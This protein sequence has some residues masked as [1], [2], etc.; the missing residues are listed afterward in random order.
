MLQSSIEYNRVLQ[1]FAE[2][3]RLLQNIT[4][5]YRVFLAHLRGPIFGLVLCCQSLFFLNLN[6]MSL[7][8]EDLTQARGIYMP[9]HCYIVLQ[10]YK[11]Y[12]GLRDYFP[13][14][15]DHEGMD[16]TP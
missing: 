1:S 4:E 12:N 7:V 9:N 2:Y 15:S 10:K 3:Y 13:E 5:Y 14:K 11:T 16:H 8:C 6:D